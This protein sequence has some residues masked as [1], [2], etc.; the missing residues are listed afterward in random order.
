M[1]TGRY[2]LVLPFFYGGDGEGIFVTPGSLA[3]QWVNT[4]G[5]FLYTS[6][7]IRWREDMMFPGFQHSSVGR[8]EDSHNGSF[9]LLWRG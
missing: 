6:K 5:R 4:D 2:N 1:G 8:G 7:P 3:S 9:K